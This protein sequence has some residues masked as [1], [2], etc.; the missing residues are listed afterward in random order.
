MSEIET[1]I[2]EH[3]SNYLEPAVEKLAKIQELEFAAS[4]TTE[5][6]I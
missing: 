4:W 1:Q 3:D 5:D 6:Q 2:E